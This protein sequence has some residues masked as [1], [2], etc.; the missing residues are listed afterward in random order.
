[1]FIIHSPKYPHSA[2][3]TAP[4][5]FAIVGKTISTALSSHLLFML[6]RS[7]PRAKPSVHLA[8]ISLNSQPGAPSHDAC[9]PGNTSS[10]SPDSKDENEKPNK[11]RLSPLPWVVH[12]GQH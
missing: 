8:I 11:E 10:E 9:V 7:F 12:L 1:M 3:N 2:S 4:I 6:S 5:F